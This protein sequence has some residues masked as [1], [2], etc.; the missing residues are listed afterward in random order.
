MVRRRLLRGT[1]VLVAALAGL[2][3]PARS[4]ACGGSPGPALE[5][6]GPA[7]R[8]AAD[9]HPPGRILLV[10]DS[11]LFQA[12]D[13]V[14]ARFEGDGWTVTMAGYMG[15]GIAGGGIG[16]VDW[17]ARVADLAGTDAPAVAVVELGTNG[18][19]LRCTTV[20]ATI[21]AIM[22]P[23]AGVDRVVWLTGRPN[24]GNAGSIAKINSALGQATARWSNLEVVPLAPWFA[25]RAGVDLDD[26]IH[27]TDEG[28]A[29]MAAE[30]GDVIDGAPP[31]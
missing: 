2:A 8:A 18:C 10:G 23:L 22:A 16:D 3:G 17:P 7:H 12:A 25:G 24:A 14:R 19:G 28:Q 11:L 15:S 21:D 29:V 31:G 6:V 30:L 1:A 9:P 20:P 27:L 5:R 4:A 26:G 13:E